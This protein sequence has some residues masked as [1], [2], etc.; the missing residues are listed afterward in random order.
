METQFGLADLAAEVAEAVGGCEETQAT[1]V[2]Q[3][4]PNN[5]VIGGTPE[6]VHPEDATPYYPRLSPHDESVETQPT[7]IDDETPIK[8]VP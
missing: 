7:E 1:E 3:D 4:S 2:A 6:K 5:E 8:T